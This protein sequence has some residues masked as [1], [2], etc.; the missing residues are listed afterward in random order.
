MQSINTENGSVL[1]LL[2]GADLHLDSPFA[3]LSPELAA[4]RRSEQRQLLS[5]LASLARQRQVDGVLLSGDVLDAARCF[6]ETGEELAR[7]LGAMGCPVFI[8]PGNH[9]PYTAQSP[10]ETLSWPDNV[11]IFSRR[12]VEQVA[13]PEKNCTIHGAAF[14]AEHEVRSPLAGFSVPEDGG[15]H[16]MVLHGDV[17]GAGEYAPLTRQDI[18]ASGLDYLALGHVHRFSGV[19]KEGNTFWAYPGCAQGR[20]FDETGEKGVL[21][22][23]LEKEACRAEFI[24]LAR[25][26]YESLTVD[27]TGW[28]DPA[29][30]LRRAL[31][32]EKTGDI[33]R[34]VLTGERTRPHWSGNWP[35]AFSA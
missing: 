2:H 18:A 13:L 8:A 6:R 28:D 5:D 19:Q 22:L 3:G 15:L 10:Y 11:H 33:Y 24:P 20:G 31:P 29:D 23:E 32:R 16:V 7:Q 21:Y 34:V 17:D 30:A 14:C 35:P 12:Q 4:L 25:R 27:V 9:D 1:R 26:R